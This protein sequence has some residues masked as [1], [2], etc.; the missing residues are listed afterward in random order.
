MPEISIIVPVYNVENYLV[1]CIE[2]ILAQTFKEFELILVN[3]GSPDNCGKI[4]DEYAQKDSRIRVIHKSNGGLSDARNSGIEISTGKYIGFVDSDDYIEPDMY[5]V[6]YNDIKKCNA[7]IACCAYYICFKNERIGSPTSKG[8]KILSVEEAINM[9]P[10]ISPGAWNKLYKKEIFE[11]IRY[12]VGK[13]NE[14]VFILMDLLERANKITF[15]PSAKYYYLQRQNSI[16]KKG[17]NSKKWDC[18]DAWKKN[19]IYVKNKYPKQIKVIEYKYFGAYI[20]ILDQ[21]IVSEN[22]RSIAEYEKVNKFIKNNILNII[23]NSYIPIKRKI[24]LIIYLLNDK[25]YKNIVNKLIN[26]R[27]LI[28]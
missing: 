28:D 21:L 15:N 3:D 1:R 24:S 2:S 19:L 11:E 4:C 10:Q 23:L 14:D 12:P 27:G 5:E 22:Y 26:K 18:I 17:F 8:L 7:D 9:L 25:A 13:L 6:L 20:Y 16:T